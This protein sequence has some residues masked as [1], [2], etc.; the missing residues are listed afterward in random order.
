MRLNQTQWLAEFFEKQI[1]IVGGICTTS[2]T[3]RT[4]AVKLFQGLWLNFLTDSI[5]PSQGLCLAQLTFTAQPA[6]LIAQERGP[7]DDTECV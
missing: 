6:L 3:E 1:E 2:A 7:Y 5:A 4:G